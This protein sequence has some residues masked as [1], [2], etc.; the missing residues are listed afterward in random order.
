MQKSIKSQIDTYLPTIE[1]F[2]EW[3]LRQ[4]YVLPSIKSNI[5]T[6]KFLDRVARQ[7]IFMPKIDNC[8]PAKIAKPPSRKAV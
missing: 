6:V 3:L 2:Y 8:R 5:I 7:E 4:K 1:K